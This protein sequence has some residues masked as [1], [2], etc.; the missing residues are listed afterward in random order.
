MTFQTSKMIPEGWREAV[1]SV[2]NV[3]EMTAFFIEILGWEVRASGNIPRTQLKSWNLAETAS[4]TFS[5]V[6][7]PGSQTGFVRIVSFKGVD[8]RRIREHDQAWETGGIFNINLRVSNMAD[9]RHKVTNA[10]WQGVAPPIRFAFG[11]FIVWEWIPRHKDGVR[12]AFVE[13]V[14]PK[15]ENWSGDKISSHLFNSTQIVSDL[16]RA[17]EFYSGMLGF[18]TYLETYGPSKEPSEHVLGL[19][20]EAMTSVNRDVKIV[21]PSGEN[22]EGSIELLEFRSYSGRDFSAYAKPPN[23]GNLMLRYPVPNVDVLI[24]YFENKRVNLEY[25]PTEC[26]MAP[27][28]NVK[29]IA[30][31][32][33]DGA[34]LEFFQELN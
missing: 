15:L 18:K 5:L 28:G 16:D 3:D 26:E 27:Y 4:A 7:N 1:I 30:I 11:P 17:M 9:I 24:A 22:N 23:L 14:R 13:R 31:R 32:A 25:A 10:G 29:I 8:Q 12:I 6:A 20:R 33:P 21:N 34:W 19:S 2:S